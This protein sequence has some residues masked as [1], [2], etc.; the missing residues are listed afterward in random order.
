[1]K[2][3]ILANVNQENLKAS[4]RMLEKR[5]DMMVEQMKNDNIDDKSKKMLELIED[6][7]FI[8]ELMQCGNVESIQDLY[9]KNGFDISAEQV[10]DL[11]KCV[12]ELIINLD[13]NDG[14]LTEEELEN[15][16]GGWSWGGF[17]G[18]LVAG[19]FVAMF[20]VLETASLGTATPFVVA[21]G[22]AVGGVVLGKAFD[23]E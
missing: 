15:I 9:K 11:L 2:E 18:G 23:Q 4:V 19:A 16:A 14:E 12:G 20:V 5:K 8:N 7:A 17:F 21:A 10:N 1:M 3:S 6:K 22:A 13:K